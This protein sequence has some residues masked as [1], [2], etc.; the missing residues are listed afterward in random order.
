MCLVALGRNAAA[1]PSATE[2]TLATALFNRA[3]ELMAQ[4]SWAEACEKFAESQRLDPGGGTL[5][6]L[7]ICH[8][9]AGK[10]AT[11]WNELYDALAVA[12]REDRA[13]RASIAREHIAAI[14]PKL[15]RVTI[16]APQSAEADA[17]EVR[18]DGAV[19]RRAAFGTPVPI[20]PGTHEVVA[21]APHREAWRSVV[22]AEPGATLRVEIPRLNDIAPLADPSHTQPTEG[23][24]RLPRSRCLRL[25]ARTRRHRPRY[26]TLA[27]SVSRHA[28]ISM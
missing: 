20:D 7:A 17:L 18:L 8:E 19:V 3:R 14:E 15:A 28:R 6:N 26:R 5:L 16:A 2:R 22:V 1:D 12:L 23:M 21:E 25:S 4:G 11:A 10:T 9:R 27:S 24:R 13:D